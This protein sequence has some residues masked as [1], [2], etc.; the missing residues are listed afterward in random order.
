[1]QEDAEL[2]TSDSTSTIVFHVDSNE[3]VRYDL[4]FYKVDI[5]NEA[6]WDPNNGLVYL[7]DGRSI[8]DFV[9][10]G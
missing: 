9:F 5:S 4:Q 7:K 8:V 10:V 1:M 2:S 3:E 6:Y